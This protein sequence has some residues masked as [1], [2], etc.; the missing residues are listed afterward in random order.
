[1][2][3]KIFLKLDVPLQSWTSLEDVLMELPEQETSY[4]QPVITTI[5]DSEYYFT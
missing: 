4:P 3:K 5:I 2:D 1:L